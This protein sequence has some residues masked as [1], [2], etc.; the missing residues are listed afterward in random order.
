VSKYGTIL[1]KNEQRRKANNYPQVSV[2]ACKEGKLEDK[3][4]SILFALARVRQNKY[5][6]RENKKGFREIA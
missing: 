3:I 6:T 4:R 5:R 1:N 2:R